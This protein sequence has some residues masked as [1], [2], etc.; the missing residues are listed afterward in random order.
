MACWL[1]SRGAGGEAH[2]NCGGKSESDHVVVSDIFGIVL[3]LLGSSHNE[4]SADGNPIQIP[5]QTKN[6]RF[7]G[8]E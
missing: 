3:L 1:E 2:K 7:C 4:Y 6:L 5:E 8:R